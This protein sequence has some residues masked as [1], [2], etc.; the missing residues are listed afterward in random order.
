[1]IYF[2]RIG[3]CEGINVNKQVH[4]MSVIIATVGIF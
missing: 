1:M 4:E 3:V 2:D